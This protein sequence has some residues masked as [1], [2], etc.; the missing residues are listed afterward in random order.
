ME[1]LHNMELASLACRYA[2]I[3]SCNLMAPHLLIPAFLD[4]TDSEECEIGIELGMDWMMGCDEIQA[5]GNRISDGM[6]KE[7]EAALD[8]GIPV[9]RI[10]FVGDPIETLTRLVF[11]EKVE[12]E[13]Y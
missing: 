13:D 4:D 10:G 6:R 1:L 2:V 9:I 3:H 12:N 7:I 11:G 5:I 8:M